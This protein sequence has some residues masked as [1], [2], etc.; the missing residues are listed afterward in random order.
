MI[1]L[2]LYFFSSKEGKLDAAIEKKKNPL[3]NPKLP[4]K[5]ETMFLG[6]DIW[7]AAIRPLCSPQWECTC[8]W[9]LLLFLRFN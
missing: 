9:L 1:L 5:A 4:R 7:S 3:K 8:Q 2:L 6:W